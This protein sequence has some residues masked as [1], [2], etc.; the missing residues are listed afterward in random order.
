MSLNS[1]GRRKTEQTIE[2][3]SLRSDWYFGADYMARLVRQAAGAAVDRIRFSGFPRQWIV[4]FEWLQIDW[5]RSIAP[6]IYIP[7]VSKFDEKQLLAEVTAAR[8]C[9]QLRLLVETVASADILFGDVLQRLDGTSLPSQIM[10]A[11]TAA[12][13]LTNWHSYTRPEVAAFEEV[14]VNWRP[15]KSKVIF[16]PCGRSRPYDK[17]PTHQRLMQKLGTWGIN[18]EE[19]DLIVITS[20]APVPQDLWSHETVCRYDTGVRDIYR[21]LT[22]LRRLLAKKKLYTEAIDCLGFR[23]YR[24]L[25][26]IVHQEGL[27]GSLRRAGPI[28]GRTIPAYKFPKKARSR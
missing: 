6:T 19:F 15:T 28:R 24:D 17:S 10:E 7:F 25:L 3:T 27:I 1:S 23:P 14:L 9:G 21:L 22:L 20:L 2:F 8:K 5:E 13:P 16:L 4:L 11:S 26:E 12:I 18:P